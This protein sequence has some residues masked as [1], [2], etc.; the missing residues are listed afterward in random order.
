MIANK[1]INKNKLGSNY[2]D[3]LWSSFRFGIIYPFI[4]PAETD[5][6]NKPQHE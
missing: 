4:T 6:T 3:V 1:Y 5:I 2:K